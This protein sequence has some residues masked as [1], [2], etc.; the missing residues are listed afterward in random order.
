MSLY[1]RLMFECTQYTE[2]RI[3]I[4]SGQALEPW[5]MRINRHGWSPTLVTGK[6]VFIDSMDIIKWVDR[7][8]PSL[9]GEAVNSTYVSEW[10]SKVDA[11]DGNLFMM[12]NG[13][14]GGLFK[15][16]TK[17]KIKVA[18]SHAARNA[19]LSDI[20]TKKIASMRSILHDVD[21]A[22]TVEANQR[23][24]A[25][26]LDEAEV[27]L[28]Q[29]KFLAGDQYSM[30]DTIFTP[31]VY[32]LYAMRKEQEYLHLRTRVREYYQLLKQ[33]PSYNKVF[34]FSDSGLAS[35]SL[36]LPALIKVFFTNL[37][38]RF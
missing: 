18:Q 29:S 20:Y 5:Y 2:K 17:W 21:D 23:E 32:R 10:L 26:L 12:A 38:G 28:A 24:L 14:A 35:A 36:F 16:I 22:A 19:D 7:Q 34:G 33:R 3:D 37:I 15:Y 13:S 25:A 27:R 11:W 4:M 30:A 9:G 8:G 31:V 6:D 1:L